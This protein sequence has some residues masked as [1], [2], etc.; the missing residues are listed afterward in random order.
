[1]KRIRGPIVRRTIPEGMELSKEQ[2]RT[3]SE[4]LIR[5]LCELHAIDYQKAGLGDFGK[6]EGYVKRQVQGWISR[7]QDARTPDA[8]DYEY[9]MAWLVEKMPADSSRPCLVH[10]D[11]KIDNV[12]L[13]PQ[14]PVEIIG[15]LDW[16][17]ATIGDPLMDLGNSIAYW[18]EN[19]DPI[20]SPEI[21]MLATNPIDGMLTRLEQ[22]ELYSKVMGYP[23]ENFGY[24]HCFGIFRTAVI[25]Q[26][27]YRRFYY[28]QTND[29]RFLAMINIVKTLEQISKYII[30]KGKL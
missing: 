2:A 3:L 26:Q 7:Y 1:M 27:L 28:K 4:N 12:I 30:D 16:E 15:V 20:Q 9:V 23:I 10:N 13:N 22:V 21:R 24:Y 14:N 6:P 29:Q 11:Y 25:S 19:E 5:V 18:V 17:M 8:P